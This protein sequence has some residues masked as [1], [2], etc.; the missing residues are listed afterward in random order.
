MTAIQ[1]S[2]VGIVTIFKLRKVNL[3][4][5][6]LIWNNLLRLAVP[7]DLLRRPHQRRHTEI[8]VEAIG[9]PLGADRRIASA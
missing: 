9:L 2:R 8:D 1:I 6:A 4:W 7:I 3:W 5:I